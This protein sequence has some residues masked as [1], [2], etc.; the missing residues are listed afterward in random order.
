M[1]EMKITSENFEKEVLK[2]ELPVLVDFF[3]DWCGP[4]KMLAPELA[5][6]A[7]EREGSVKVGKVN[8]D[9][10]SELAAKF[11]IMSIPAVILFQNGKAVQTAIGFRPKA[12]LEKLLDA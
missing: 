10:E 6:L 1:A 2:S 4:C 3:A 11:G 8:V 7:K 9:E 5:M 12:E